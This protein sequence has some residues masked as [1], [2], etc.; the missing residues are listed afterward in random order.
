M[1]V[2]LLEDQGHFEETGSFVQG[3]NAFP[4]DPPYL[5]QADLLVSSFRD[6]ES[7]DPP[8]LSQADLLV[9]SF[10]DVESGGQRHTGGPFALCGVLID[11]VQDSSTVGEAHT[12]GQTGSGKG[13]GGGA[14]VLC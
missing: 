11:Q 1:E 4:S 6:V 5:S 10:R 9:S 2:C 7:G 12:I 8:Y 13:R 3:P 14:P